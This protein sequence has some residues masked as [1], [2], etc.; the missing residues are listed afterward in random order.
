MIQGAA[1]NNDGARKASFTAPSV[2]GQA[3]GHRDGA[4]ARR[5]RSRDDRRTSRRTAPARALG[6]PIEIAGLTQAFRAGGA[7]GTGFCAIGSVKTQHRPPRRRGRRRRAD[8]GGARAAS[9][10]RCRRR[11][12]FERAEPEA[13]LRA[14]PFFVNATLARLAGA[15]ARRA[16]PASAR[17][18]SAAR[19]R[20]SCSRRRRRRD[21][22]RRRTARRRSCSCSRHATPKALD[23]QAREPRR[24]SR[25][26]AGASISPTSRTRC[27][28]GRRRFAH[29]RASSAATRATRRRAARR[30]RIRSA[31]TIVSGDASTRASRSCSR[32][33]A[34]STPAWARRCTRREPRLPRGRSTRARALLRPHLGVDLRDG[35]VSRRRSR[36]RRRGA[37]DADGDHAAGAVRDRVRA[38]ASSGCRGASSPTR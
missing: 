5:H 30:R 8:Q 15:T 33:R 25:R 19:T 35:A 4:G 29:R 10:D 3:A 18:A 24:A 26:R 22:V 28:S 27:R 1:L 14:T 13:R 7:D 21:R 34:R 38:R 36:D 9:Q 37:A 12:H 11:M 20:T 31:C 23:A 16:A 32:A 2:D 17:S 6:D